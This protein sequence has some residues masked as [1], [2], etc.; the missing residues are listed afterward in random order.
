MIGATGL[1]A[2]DDDD[3][4]ELRPL[5]VPAAN[6]VVAD[7]HRHHGPIP[8][9]FAW[10]CVGAFVNGRCVGVAIAGRP[11]NRN[12]DDGMTVEVLRV[13]TDGTRNAPSLLLGSCARAAKAIGAWRCITYTLDRESGASLRAA[14]WRLEKCGIK[15]W[16]THE[17]SRKG[18][19]RRDHMSEAKSRWAVQFK[20]APSRCAA[21]LK[22]GGADAVAEIS[23]LFAAECE[24][25]A[26][27]LGS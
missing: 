14:G 16:W 6:N 13:A 18:A 20:P 24:R 22:R 7:L 3:R 4:L 21:P 25:R 26:E 27:E 23:D 10:F 9:G 8:G 15:S 17:G 11:T 19:I 1:D 2:R 12:N 5:T